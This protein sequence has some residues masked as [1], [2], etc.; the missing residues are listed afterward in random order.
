MPNRFRTFA[1]MLLAAVLVA[2]FAAGVSA[3]PLKV[4]ITQ[5]VE[6]PSLDKARQG[7]IDRLTELGY[8]E[9]QDIVYDIHSA[10][11][12][13]S[14]ARAIAEKFLADRVDMVLAIA[15]PTAQ[16]AAQVIKE[17]PILIT[18]VTDPVAAGLVESIERPGTNVTGTSDLTPVEAQLTLL[19]LI[20]PAATRVGIV[21]NAGETNSV[22]QVQ[23]ARNVAAQRGLQVV[24]ATAGNSSEVLQAAQSLQ[25]RV[26]AIYVPTDNTVV[27]AIDA[28]V[29]VAERLKLPLIVGEES[30]VE[31]G[32]LATIGIDY[33]QLGRQ[34]ADIAHRVFQGENP[35]EIPI[36]YQA[37]QTIIVNLGAAQ[38][39]NVQIPSE[40]IAEAARVIN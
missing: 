30:S 23:I 7:F 11:G 20:A 15:T 39:M 13:L 10:Q 12:D 33:Y 8:V 18:A 24:E 22:V 34:T 35:A 21:Y 32:G 16:A 2:V 3:A 29:A 37:E 1:R 25:G 17:I 5:I 19:K 27:S 6:H 31:Q 4:G 38:R 9:G 40:L 26:D 36:E 28:V 14:V